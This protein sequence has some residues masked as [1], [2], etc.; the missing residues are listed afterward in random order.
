MAKVLLLCFRA[1]GDYCPLAMRQLS[2]PIGAAG[3]AFP[4]QRKYVHASAMGDVF[5]L[6][7]I[8]MKFEAGAAAGYP[9]FVPLRWV[10]NIRRSGNTRSR[11]SPQY[12]QFE[13]GKTIALSEVKR[14][15]KDAAKEVCFTY[16]PAVAGPFTRVVGGEHVADI[17]C[18]TV[19]I[20]GTATPPLPDQLGNDHDD[21]DAWVSLTRALAYAFRSEKKL[22]GAGD[23]CFVRLTEATE[24]TEKT[25]GS[26][27]AFE[28][29]K[30]TL[31]V[32]Q[33]YEVELWSMFLPEKEASSD[34]IAY[35]L[36]FV[37]DEIDAP[38]RDIMITP[39]HQFHTLQVTPRKATDTLLSFVADPNHKSYV[40]D[41]G[42]HCRFYRHDIE[43]VRG[44]LADVRVCAGSRTGLGFL[45]ERRYALC[46]SEDSVVR[47]VAQ[48][49][50]PLNAA[51]GG[52][53]HWALRLIGAV[54]NGKDAWDL[55]F[56][57]LVKNDKRHKAPR[58][59]RITTEY[60][61]SE[62][63]VLLNAA[64]RDGPR[65]C[66][67]RPAS[68]EGEVEFDLR[69][70]E[71]SKG[72]TAF[73]GQTGSGKSYSLGVLVEEMLR[74]GMKMLVLDPNSDFIRFAAKHRDM[75]KEPDKDDIAHQK[76]IADQKRDYAKWSRIANPN[77][78]IRILT[79]RPRGKQPQEAIATW[80]TCHLAFSD[81]D[82]RQ[83]AALI[84]VERS[85][86]D[87]YA[88]HH[89]TLKG[90]RRPFGPSKLIDKLK[91]TA[92]SGS[93]SFRYKL[94]Q[95]YENYEV[96]EAGIWHTA[97]AKGSDKSVNDHLAAFY[98]ASGPRLLG[99]DL[100]SVGNQD[101]RLL[102]AGEVLKA[103]KKLAEQKGNKDNKIFIV[104]D[105]AHNVVPAQPALELQKVSTEYVNWIAGEGRKYGLS[106]VLVTQRPSKI[107]PNSLGMVSN[108]VCMKVTN[109]EDLDVVKRT[110][111]NVPMALLDE[112]PRLKQGAAVVSGALIP[113]PCILE[114]GRRLADEGL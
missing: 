65:R 52:E 37:E 43:I 2:L 85:D 38:I 15:L 81:F 79:N 33:S 7:L 30:L 105:E 109:L 75:E 103:I 28:K 86:V 87:L 48:V 70:K 61:A 20:D 21:D 9:L 8:C 72:H 47:Y 27:Q 94:A 23:P 100:G 104:I 101:A 69:S 88:E 98:A 32:H 80:D 24:K 92:E 39:G 111:G 44:D 4:Y 10:T 89:R 18:T 107:H 95:L 97:G 16:S 60:P 91:N 56:P 76:Q 59:A 67:L 71:L 1:N 77:D 11:A 35:R 49:D 31:Q 3:D 113:F 5:P 96:A 62:L 108:L 25:S 22:F 42:L 29:G 46:E 93:Q 55:D 13:L 114:F 26:V 45:T 110:F 17:L 41:I 102:V 19:D 78:S 14:H 84:G 106:L 64:A 12:Y 57:H 40:T 34:R 6:G 82:S 99:V 73:F 112:V 74:S 53:P 83:L 36:S 66:K 58:L 63:G 68:S 90:L 50:R 54:T 51:S